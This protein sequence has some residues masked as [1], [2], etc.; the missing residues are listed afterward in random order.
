MK[1][2]ISVVLA[3]TL[4]VFG[5]MFI[6]F[7]TLAQETGLKNYYCPKCHTHVESV[8]KP[9][10]SSCPGGGGHEWRNLGE[11]GNKLYQCSKCG[12]VVKS[13]DTPYG[14]CPCKNSG[15]HNWKRIS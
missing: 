13:K 5:V 6:S 10:A 2:H 1:N 7:V 12:L 8:N 3:V 11:V 15:G 9:F 4:V 14:G